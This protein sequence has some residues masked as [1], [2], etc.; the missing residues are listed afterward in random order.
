MVWRYSSQT[1]GVTAGTLASP[2]CSA[3]CNRY[4]LIREDS[5]GYAK[6]IVALNHFGQAALTD[7]MVPQLYREIQAS[8]PY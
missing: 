3:T 4:N 2:A 6:L 5:E 8:I 1:S 7:D